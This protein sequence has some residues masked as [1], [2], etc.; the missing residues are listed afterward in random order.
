MMYPDIQIESLE[1]A[2]KRIE[3]GRES[4]AGIDVSLFV[5][6]ALNLFIYFDDRRS[7]LEFQIDPCIPDMK[8]QLVRIKR[9]HHNHS[10]SLL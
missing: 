8:T 2:V 3:P 10:Y 5:A 1:N 9:H 7:G 4:Y 6:N